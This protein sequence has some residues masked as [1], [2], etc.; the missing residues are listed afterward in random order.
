MT[1]PLYSYD[2]AF[3]G[4]IPERTALRMERDG[5]A[6]LVRHKKGGIARDQA[7]APW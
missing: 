4:M 6:K 7:Q 1:I 3:Q 5:Q 2:L